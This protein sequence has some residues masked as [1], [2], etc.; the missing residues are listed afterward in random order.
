MLGASFPSVQRLN[1]PVCANL[2]ESPLRYLPI[3]RRVFAYRTQELSLNKGMDSKTPRPVKRG[4]CFV[5][6]ERYPRATIALQLGA[7]TLGICLLAWGLNGCSAA[8]KEPVTLTFLDPEWSH[9]SRDRRSI[10]EDVLQEFTRDTGIRVTHLPAPESSP[11]QLAL[12]RDLLKKGAPT[13]D[14]YGIDVIWPGILDQYLVDLKP[15]FTAEL[16]SQD[17]EVTANHTAKNKLAAWVVPDRAANPE[18]LFAQQERETILKAAVG[19]L[20]PAIRKAVEVGQLQDRSMRETADVLGISVAAAKAR[21]FH[22]RAALRKSRRLKSMNKVRFPL[23]A[24][25]VRVPPA[26]IRERFT[27]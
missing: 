14:V 1:N 5:R 27:C 23:I 19:D 12:I 3:G 4:P 25:T 6:I 22:A 11:D 24:F 18:R 7:W 8:P 2:L 10:S 15:Y 13:P 16:A 9:D 17:P 26:E 21:L 20:R